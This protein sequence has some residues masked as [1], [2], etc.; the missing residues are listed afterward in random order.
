[1]EVVLCWPVIVMIVLLVLGS[2]VAIGLYCQ[3]WTRQWRST[4]YRSRYQVLEG[5]EDVN[6][7]MSDMKG[8]KARVRQDGYECAFSE[9]EEMDLGYEKV[10]V[11]WTPNGSRVHFGQCG[12]MQ[13]ATHVQSRLLCQLCQ[14]DYLRHGSG[15]AGMKKGLGKGYTT[16]KVIKAPSSD[17]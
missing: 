8:H 5:H 17:I 3:P 9:C 4:R 1:M 7:E 6:S 13:N 12:P 16:R 2:G 10:Y 14:K 11:Y 15:K